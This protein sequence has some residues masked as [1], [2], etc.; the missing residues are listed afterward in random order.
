MN[1]FDTLVKECGPQEI[2]GQLTGKKDPDFSIEDYL[3]FAE[4]FP[5]KSKLAKEWIVLFSLYN[6]ILKY[7]EK[8]LEETPQK[9]NDKHRVNIGGK[10][11]EIDINEGIPKKITEKYD[12]E[13]LNS[14]LNI[15]DEMTTR[16][17][18]KQL[19]ELTLEEAKQLLPNDIKHYSQELDRER[20]MLQKEEQRNYQ[21]AKTN[22]EIES[23]WYDF[24]QIPVQ[25]SITVMGKAE[26]EKF[27]PKLYEE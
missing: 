3:D 7:K 9:T 14:W 20:I 11:Y 17:S 1:G 4:K 5:V 26:I 8:E 22:L 25:K 12:G 19:S 24:R 15:P 2:I 18:R 16:K 21:E 6:E 23:A 10:I 13:D 27:D